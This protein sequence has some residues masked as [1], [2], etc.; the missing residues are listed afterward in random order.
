MPRA[1]RSVASAVADTPSRRR[2]TTGDADGPDESGWPR[3]ERAAP[4]GPRRLLSRTLTVRRP[5][6]QHGRRARVDG[7]QRVWR[8]ERGDL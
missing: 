1:R 2:W 6:R 3:G 7:M 8:A 5:Q 4:T